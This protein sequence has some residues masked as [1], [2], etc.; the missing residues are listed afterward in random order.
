MK[1]AAVPCGISRRSVPLDLIAQAALSSVLS[2]SLLGREQLF[3]FQILNRPPH[4]RLGEFEFI[5][6]RRDRGPTFP[7]SIRPIR[8]VQIHRHRT[9]REVC[10]IKKIKTAH[11]L[12]SCSAEPCG[13]V[14]PFRFCGTVH[15]FG[16][17]FGLSRPTR[18]ARHSPFG[19]PPI[20]R[21]GISS[22]SRR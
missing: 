3:L 20:N 17:P 8:K 1:K 10:R 11:C 22:R 7:G 6:N 2:V 12:P 5:R 14:P 16:S 4:G 18:S 15:A 21:D 19:L 13:S 9:V